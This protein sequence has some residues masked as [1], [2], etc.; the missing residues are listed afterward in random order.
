MFEGTKKIL[1][2]KLRH[3]GDVLLA[4]PAIR[5][6]KESFRDVSVSVLVN[7]GTEDMLTLN[8]LIDEVICF[9]RG[10]K[11][12]SAGRRIGEEL[13]LVTELRKKRF[14]MTVDLTGG[15]RAALI[16]SFIGARFRLGYQ[17]KGGFAGKKFMYS[18]RAKRPEAR[19]HTVLRDLGLLRAFGIDTNDLSV[20]IYASEEDSE[21][22][23][24][25]LA[26]NGIPEGTT[27]V[28]VHPTSR[29]LFKC[30]TDSG[31]AFVIDRLME[32]GFAVVVTSGPDEK[33]MA[34]VASIIALT[35]RKPV[36]LSGRL[37][38]KQMAALSAKA[39]F[40]FGVDT[41]PMHMAAAAGARVVSVFGPSGAFDWGPWDNGA[42]ASFKPETGDGAIISNTPYPLRSG[43]Q[44]F[45]RNIVIQ[46]AR[47]CVPC[48]KD[49]C[50]GSKKSDCLDELSPEFVWDIIERSVI[51]TADSGDK[52][53]KWRKEPKGRAK[54]D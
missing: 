9:K 50:D 32:R 8:P 35:E 46:D 33:E 21:S 38:L 16:G 53:G 52:A 23:S 13:K 4:A 7:S 42:A 49:G 54:G 30:W 24:G 26:E 10:I 43:V 29:W 48:G 37:T 15:D 45:G 40:F 36:D 2:V 1:V 12:L 41:A 44:T 22:V 28:H 20:K 31:M 6:L 34:K 47:E 39:A 51:S 27:F 18:H 25:L 3:I 5:A 14:D 11:G 19:T 17:P